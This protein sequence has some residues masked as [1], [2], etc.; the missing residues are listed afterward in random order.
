MKNQIGFYLAPYWCIRP[1]PGGRGKGS[2]GTLWK[3]GPRL[4]R[5]SEVFSLLRSLFSE[6]GASSDWRRLHEP[7]NTV[8]QH[9]RNAKAEY[10]TNCPDFELCLRRLDGL[11]RFV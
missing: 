3:T 10:T 11:K 5:N 1:K 8:V 4:C 7:R 2:K 6:H 9:S